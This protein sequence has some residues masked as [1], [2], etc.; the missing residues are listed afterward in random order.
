MFKRLPLVAALLCG[1]NFPTLAQTGATAEPP[2]DTAG[3]LAALK[4]LREKQT[5]TNK[6]TR[7][8]LITDLQARAA[9][10]TASVDFY[11]AA[12]KATEFDGES[13][14]QTL[15]VE[16]KKKDATHMKSRDFQ[17]ALHLHLNWLIITLQ[18]A[19]GTE[20]KTL[21]PSIIA[22]AQQARLEQDAGN[23]D[24]ML[25]TRVD[26]GLFTRWYQLGGLLSN[27]ENWE[28]TPGNS[29]G[30]YQKIIQAEYRK[31]KDAHI[32]EYWD[33]KLQREATKAAKS[34][35]A[36]DV[37]RFDQVRK[38]ALLWN[39]AEDVLSIGLKSRAATDMLALIKAYPVHPDAQKWMSRLEDILS[40]KA[41]MAGAIA[42]GDAAPQ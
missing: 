19:S 37:G 41:D 13:H 22:Q 14:A 23:T 8:K 39:R 38:P 25:R 42:D 35:L 33:A 2:L 11:V 29:D 12:K 5:D 1:M 17:A 40:G 15:F 7:G 4:A 10:P 32:T 18:R 24:A 27:V 20:V 30:I 36:F 21:L 16:W 34:A 26:D 3:M 31:Q 9:N 6:T 28:M